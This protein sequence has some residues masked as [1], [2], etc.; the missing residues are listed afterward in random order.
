LIF[1]IFTANGFRMNMSKPSWLEYKG[2]LG[3]DFPNLPYYQG[4][5]GVKITQSKAI[6]RYLGRRHGLEGK[7]QEE[8]VRIDLLADTLTDYI[9]ALTGLSYN[10]GFS[11]E[12]LATFAAGLA[13]RLANLEAFLAK[14]NG[15]WCAGKSLTW[16]DFLTWETLDQHRLLVSGCLKNLPWIDQFMT[17]FAALPQVSAYLTRPTYRPFPIWSM[18]AKYGYRPT[19]S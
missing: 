18:R 6:L 8:Q 3:F 16:V 7:T 11:S 19:S 2:G 12:L 17:R 13:P 1:A 4:P 10:P 14:S 5:D 15:Q 9:Q